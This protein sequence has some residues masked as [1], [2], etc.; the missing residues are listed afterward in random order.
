MSKRIYHHYTKCEEYQTNMWLS[1]PVSERQALIDQSYNLMLDFDGFYNAM[2]RVITEW[3]F[4]CEA[5]FTAS[6]INH[7][8]WIGHAGCALNHNAPEELTRLAWRQL[9]QEQQ[10]LANLAADKVINEWRSLNA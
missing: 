1:V 10:D 8:A 5:A 6:V 7:Q 9:A 3:K 4:S 2:K